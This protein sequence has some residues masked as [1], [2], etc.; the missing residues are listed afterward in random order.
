M[1]SGLVVREHI[2]GENCHYCPRTARFTVHHNCSWPT[3]DVC[4]QHLN[5]DNELFDTD[6]A[7]DASMY[8]YNGHD[9]IAVVREKLNT[10]DECSADSFVKTSQGT[11]WCRGHFR[12]AFSKHLTADMITDQI[13]G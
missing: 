2:D 4:E 3:F 11:V 5:Q 7:P 1:I 12:I 8:Y 9:W 10:C 6:D 13:A